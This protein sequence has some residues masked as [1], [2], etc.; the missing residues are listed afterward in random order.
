MNIRSTEATVN[1]KIITL[2]SEPG[3]FLF[4]PPKAFPHVREAWTMSRYETHWLVI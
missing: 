4:L 2:K 3:D 1:Q